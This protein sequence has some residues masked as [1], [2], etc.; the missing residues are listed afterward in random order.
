MKNTEINDRGSKE[1]PFP[2]DQEGNANLCCCYL[3]ESDGSYSD[4]CPRPVS[5][6]C[7]TDPAGDSG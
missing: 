6:C 3:R 1:C 5:D 2:Q 4:P 7:D